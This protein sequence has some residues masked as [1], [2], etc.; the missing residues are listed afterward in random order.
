MA[1][2]AGPHQSA[3]PARVHRKRSVSSS[4]LRHALADQLHAGEVGHPWSGRSFRV[5]WGSREQ[6]SV[7]LVVPDVVAEVAVDVAR[8]SAG[9]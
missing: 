7:R 3:A 9:R 2:G 5:G 6:L 1:K 4:T 8:G